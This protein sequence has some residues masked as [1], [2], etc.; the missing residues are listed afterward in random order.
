MPSGNRRVSAVSPVSCPEPAAAVV[1]PRPGRLWGK[2]RAPGKSGQVCL[3]FSLRL[4][5]KETMGVLATKACLSL[6]PHSRE[7]QWSRCGQIY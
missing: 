1:F 5:V 3:A 7:R 4:L 2:M 6:S